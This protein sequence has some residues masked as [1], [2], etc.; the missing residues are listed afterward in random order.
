MQLGEPHDV[1]PPTLGAIDDIE[2]FLERGRVG[3]SHQCGKFM[4]DAE[5]HPQT[6]FCAMPAISTSR[7]RIRQ[8][9]VTAGGGSRA[10]REFALG[11]PNDAETR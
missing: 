9:R 5:F 11:A 8:Q 1:E 6:L 7:A 10:V 3:T 2:G 4:K